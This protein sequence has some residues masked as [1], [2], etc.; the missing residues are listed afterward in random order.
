MGALIDLVRWIIR[1][2]WQWFPLVL[3]VVVPVGTMTA[4][5][6]HLPKRKKR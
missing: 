5:H 4:D 1:H 6:S 2:Y 3:L